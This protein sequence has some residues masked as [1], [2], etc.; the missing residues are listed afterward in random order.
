[1]SSPKDSDE[2]TKAGKVLT[3]ALTECM[4]LDTSVTTN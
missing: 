4:G 2:T 3:T 1:M